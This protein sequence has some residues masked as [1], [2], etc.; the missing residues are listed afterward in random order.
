MRP[1][2]AEKS[3]EYMRIMDD[4]NQLRAQPLNV[5]DAFENIDD[6]ASYV[7]YCLRNPHG[8]GHNSHKTHLSSTLY[9]SLIAYTGQVSFSMRYVKAGE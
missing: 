1:T 3:E 2:T 6:L 9:A 8:K 5:R 7:T 4:V